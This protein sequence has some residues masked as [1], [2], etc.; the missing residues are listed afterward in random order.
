MS[1]SADY[2]Q[3]LTRLNHMTASKEEVRVVEF[4]AHSIKG[5]QAGKEILANSVVG[6][7]ARIA[8]EIRNSEKAPNKTPKHRL[9]V[10]SEKSRVPSSLDA[11]NF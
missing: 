8:K 3:L 1:S 7:A 6:Y 9:I 5:F 2:I 4:T 10:F 11:L